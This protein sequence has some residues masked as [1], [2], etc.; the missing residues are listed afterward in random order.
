M[1]RR[2]II[3]MLIVTGLLSAGPATAADLR[4]T[5][6]RPVALPGVT[7][8]GGSY[9]FRMVGPRVVQVLSA[10]LRTVYAMT[11]TIPTVRTEA[12]ARLEATLEEAPEGAPPALDRWFPP[13][14]FTGHEVIHPMRVERVRDVFEPIDLTPEPMPYECYEV[15]EG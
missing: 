1:N 11:M 5:F 9:V 3:A 10:D 15:V 7:L 8:P 6:S 4:M 14:E 13:W 12:T 2:S